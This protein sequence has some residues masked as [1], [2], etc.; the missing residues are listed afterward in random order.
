MSLF[1]ASIT[2]LDL[3][4][5]MCANIFWGCDPGDRNISWVKWKNIP[6]SK[7]EGGLEIG[8]LFAVDNEDF[9]PNLMGH[10]LLLL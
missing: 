4:E 1:E 2:I 10:G 5:F 6:A 9:Q 8:S 3:Y 7:D